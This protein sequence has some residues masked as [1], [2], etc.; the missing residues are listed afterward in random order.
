MA[1][2]KTNKSQAIR[3]YKQA[4]PEA[5]PTEIA[6]ALGNVPPAM[7]SNVLSKAGISKRKRRRGR[8][9]GS[10]T[11]AAAAATTSRNGRTFEPVILAVQLIRECGGDVAAAKSAIDAARTVAKL[12]AK[13]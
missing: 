6:R 13:S 12:L 3:D 2:R 5:G 4:H 11:P 9:K 7:V 1:K 8:K 10:V